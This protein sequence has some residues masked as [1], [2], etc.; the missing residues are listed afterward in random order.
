MASY[1][2]IRLPSDSL[3]RWRWD[4]AS[5]ARTPADTESMEASPDLLPDGGALMWARVS[6]VSPAWLGLCWCQDASAS[7]ALRPVFWWA[8][9]AP[10]KGLAPGQGVVM[11]HKLTRVLVL[12]LLW[13]IGATVGCIHS[14]TGTH[15]P[16]LTHM[17]LAHSGALNISLSNISTATHTVL[18]A[19]ERK[20]E[21]ILW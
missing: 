21:G 4:R 20:N 18:R 10:L 9:A 11:G 2:T 12:F 8:A 13:K 6:L 15:R 19:R 3:S 1:Q 5:E 14:Q 16:T 17:Q 7:R